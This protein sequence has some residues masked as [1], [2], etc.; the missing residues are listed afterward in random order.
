M[1]ASLLRT[2]LYIPP[3]PEEIISRP[4]LIERLN[5]AVKGK[6]TLVSA[7][8]GFGKTTLLSDWAH[9]MLPPRPQ[10]PARIAWLSLDKDDNDPDRFWNYVIGALQTVGKELG[11]VSSE[12]LNSKSR[13]PLKSIVSTL[14]NEI[15]ESPFAVAL[16]LDDYHTIETPTIHETLAF[17]IDHMPRQIHLVIAGRADPPL[18]LARLRVRGQITELRS[19]DLR[20]TLE[21][22]RAFLNES[23]GLSLSNESLAV[24]EGRTEGW[25]A[26]LQMAAVSL[27]GR[28]DAPDFIRT[29]SGTHHYI[30]DYLVEE[31]L[32]RQEPPV[33]QFLLETSILDR[34]S[35]PLCDAVTGGSNSQ[36]MLERL[37]HAN[38]FLIPLDEERIWFRYHQLFADLLRNQLRRVSPELFLIL[39]RRACDWFE[40][41]GLTTEAV[42]HALAAK[43]LSHAADL[44]ERVAIP[45]IIEGRYS[46][47][48]R[49]LSLLP[50]DIIATRPWLLVSLAS[51]RLTSGKF[52]SVEQL[53]NSA[54]TL[55][56][57]PHAASRTPAERDAL[58]HY[59]TAVRAMLACVRGDVPRIIELGTDALAHLPPDQSTARCLI[60]FDL[61]VAHWLKGDMDRAL[62][63]FNEAIAL[64]TA[65]RNFFIA[66]VAMG[67]AADI[68]IMY[69]RLDEA[70]RISERAI[71]LSTEWGA[72]F[73][74]PAAS[75]AHM[76]LAKAL[77]HR[78]RLNEAMREGLRG[79]E[80]ST[81]G[82]ETTVD[83][84]AL[85]V[86]ALLS[87]L[88]G[89]TGPIGEA[90]ERA[91]RIAFASQNPFIVALAEA[92]L[93]RLA[94]FKGDLA[95]ASHWADSCGID[96]QEVPDACREA[97]YLTLVRVR[98]AR[99][100]TQGLS[101]ALEPL[102]QRAQSEGRIGSL[103]EILALESLAL[104]AE[105]HFGEA[106]VK[107]EEA[108]SLAEPQGFV[109]VF[110]DEGA[111]M[112]NLLT[113]ARSKGLHPYT[114]TLLKACP[115]FPPSPP[116]AGLSRREIEVLRLIAAGASNREI[117]ERLFLSIGTVKKHTDNIYAKL[118]AHKRTLA[119]SRAREMGL[120]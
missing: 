83:L 105:G 5:T 20:F 46:S 66:L 12:M 2:K 25:I 96:L 45:I 36:E 16:V 23:K 120:M 86:L 92:W 9:R 91:R 22:T 40:K 71:T 33:R 117:A 52:D 70:I 103:I 6:L 34:L 112:Q 11:R 44:I 114:E 74:L 100:Q 3:V 30:M 39:H 26:S 35:G 84:M 76:S 72:G 42:H 88:E 50:E 64:G 89:K 4:R 90:L 99:R 7:P 53:L 69:G 118:G 111:P 17:L 48:R 28:R 68:Q 59:I 78:N 108:L 94:L 41:E 106:L 18:P 29:F 81:E 79:I 8:A 107:I 58:R 62:S 82:S 95:Q 13:P 51:V 57:E 43:D 32:D 61:G 31:V 97:A 73:P 85:P 56:T 60:F 119:I 14:I 87:R 93:A 63:Y 75:Y 80:F 21:E 102:R 54:G 37:L 104:H 49:W 67:Y 27:Q 113:G 110:M 1:P 15:A 38:L 65:S 55:M 19:P 101:E 77:Y 47:L 109:R 115:T 116:T 98:L 24:L 10:A